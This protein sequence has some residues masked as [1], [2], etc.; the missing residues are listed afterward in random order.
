[1]NSA[2]NRRLAG[3]GAVIT[4]M[5][6]AGHTGAQDA[7]ELARC[8]TIEDGAERLAC[9]DAASGKNEPAP[10][11]ALEPA[12]EPATEPLLVA[13]VEEAATQDD[14]AVLTDEVGQEQLDRDEPQDEERTMVRGTVTSCERDPSGRYY[15]VFDNGQV[16]KQK[17]SDRLAFR[18][19][20]FDV[21]IERDFF[22]YRMRI[23]GQ[24]KDIRISRIR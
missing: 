21:S 24:G 16:W 1:M 20:R 4:L 10:E 3:K 23:E 14:I 8:S 11:P 9:Y 7:A 17:D 22:G 13:P 18:D 2:T 19:C 15:F 12:P 5:L 6:V